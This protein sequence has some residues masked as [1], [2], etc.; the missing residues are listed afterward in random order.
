[1]FVRDCMSSPV[2]TITADTPF[3]SALQT[4]QTHRFRRLPVVDKNGNLAGIVSERDLLHA[5]PSPASSLSVW[6]HNYLLSRLTVQQVMTRAIIIT[7]PDTPVEH[8]ASLMI[9]NKIGG[10]PVV[11]AQDRV[12][13]MIT[14]TDIFRIFV[15]MLDGQEDSVRLTLELPEDQG[16]PFEL[17]GSISILGGELVSYGAFGHAHGIRRIL[18]VVKGVSLLDLQSILHRHQVQVTSGV[19][20][21]GLPFLDTLPIGSHMDFLTGALL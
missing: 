21:P 2:V 11:N 8:A 18:M 9:A 16:L 14:E 19:E 17:I 20:M 13:G 15:E 3:Q 6:E 10:L 7:T 5:A 1:M 4:M 12:V